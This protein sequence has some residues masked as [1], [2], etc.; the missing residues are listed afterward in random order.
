MTL[1]FASNRPDR[2][3]DGGTAYEIDVVIGI[4]G[5]CNSVEMVSC[6]VPAKEDSDERRLRGD[7]EDKHGEEQRNTSSWKIGRRAGG[8]DE[9][10]G[11]C[12]LVQSRT[13]QNE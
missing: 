10:R 6:M 7:K 3:M 1:N 8:K 5:N 4:S 9:Q 12:W 2:W 11:L 13:E